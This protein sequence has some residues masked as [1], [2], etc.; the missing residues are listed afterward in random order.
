MRC[1]FADDANGGPQLHVERRHEALILFL[2]TVLQLQRA[3]LVERCVPRRRH[4]SR[5]ARDRARRP[6]AIGEIT[7]E[8]FAFV[9]R[10]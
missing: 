4:Q 5:G 3:P 1:R 2:E 10:D 8:H 7:S 9:G 6:S